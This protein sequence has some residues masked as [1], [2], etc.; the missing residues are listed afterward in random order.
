MS[1]RVQRALRRGWSTASSGRI[2]LH[3]V[4]RSAGF[5]L[6]L[7]MFVTVGLL[8][9]SVV[10]LNRTVFSLIISTRSANTLKAFHV[11]EAGVDEAFWVLAKSGGVFAAADGWSVPPQPCLLG[12]CYRK[13]LDFSGG[14]TT[15]ID[16]VDGNGAFP[17]ITVTGTAANSSRRLEI[18][19]Q[20]GQSAPLSGVAISNKRP[21]AVVWFDTF[22]DPA[23]ITGQIAVYH[24]KSQSVYLESGSLVE[25]F[26]SGAGGNIS[27]AWMSDPG[28][29]NQQAT[30]L[31][32]CWGGNPNMF[33]AI[34]SETCPY[35]AEVY[36]EGEALTIPNSA[37]QTFEDVSIPP[38]L[39]PLPYHSNGAQNAYNVPKNE[40]VTLPGGSYK[41]GALTI[42][43]GGTLR[44][45][46]PATL[47]VDGS[48]QLE[49]QAS[50]VFESDQVS[51]VYV[52]SYGGQNIVFEQ[53]ES[54]T[55]KSQPAGAAP[56]TD[57]VQVKVTSRGGTYV[58]L[59]GGSSFHGSIYA[60]YH[61]SRM[62]EICPPGAGGGPCSRDIRGLTSVVAGRMEIKG[63][64]VIFTESASQNPSGP[65]QPKIVQW[66][67]LKN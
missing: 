27:V 23:Q 16:I 37:L 60:P 10:G 39:P 47:Y 62:W 40:E 59:D 66:R 44:F 42:K 8:G 56:V 2:A 61:V 50:L 33:T 65:T 45:S 15:T 54:S 11:A 30:G 21:D 55:V 14:G 49:K 57:G 31:T 36:T 64:S 67:E 43:Q 41:F 19:V 58:R 20:A 1:G 5:F 3:D 51:T 48:L 35:T 53:L 29:G 38:N 22:A 17:T 24:G 52:D 28:D 46:G 7:S 34:R 9:L 6:L 32:G 26:P 12:N 18:V 13:T 4:H 25:K 63:A